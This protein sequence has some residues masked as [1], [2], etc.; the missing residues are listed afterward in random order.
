MNLGLLA[1]NFPA[2]QWESAWKVDLSREEKGEK[3]EPW[4]IIRA[5]HTSILCKLL[6]FLGL[7]SYKR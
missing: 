7:S 4:N 5:S 2:S 1:A 3:T 6:D